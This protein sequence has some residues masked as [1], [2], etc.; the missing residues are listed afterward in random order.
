MKNTKND[1][2]TDTS[3]KQKNEKSYKKPIIAA[4]IIILALLLAFVSCQHMNGNGPGKSGLEWDVNAEVGGLEKRSE[5]E[6]KAELNEKVKDGMI[7]IIMNTNPIFED[8]KSAGNLMIVNSERNLH[9]QVVYI[10]L[11]DTEEE[12]Y[13]SGAIAVGSKIENA[14]LDVDLD[15]G[16]YECVAYFNN[17]DMETGNFLGTAGA[18]ITIT[19]LK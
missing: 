7:N 5:E 18:E 8:G 12:I 19:V 4:I 16:T 2:V 17:V 15:A 14:K 11:K 13:R 6:I 3:I 9:P 1:A 10:V